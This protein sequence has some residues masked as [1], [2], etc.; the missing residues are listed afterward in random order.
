M[1]NI[2]PALYQSNTKLSEKVIDL[3]S[4]IQYMNMFNATFHVIVDSI[5][6]FDVDLFDS[7][8]EDMLKRNSKVAFLTCNLCA[9]DFYREDMA[10]RSCDDYTTEM[11]KT[12]SIFQLFSEFNLQSLYL[13][14]ARN[15]YKLCP[16]I[17]NNVNFNEVYISGETVETARL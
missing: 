2:A 9:F 15:K 12:R 1:F 6:S 13:M 14:L 3:K 5:S 8:V 16:L 10:L 4:W 11:R 7:E 17:F